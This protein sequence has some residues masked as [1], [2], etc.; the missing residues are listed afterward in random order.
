MDT[1][2]VTKILTKFHVVRDAKEFDNFLYTFSIKIK[3]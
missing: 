2:I 1:E 3:V